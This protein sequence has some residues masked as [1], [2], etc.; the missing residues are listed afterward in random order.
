MN[1]LNCL[2]NIHFSVFSTYV[3][4][5]CSKTVEQVFKTNKQIREYYIIVFWLKTKDT[6]RTAFFF[7]RKPDK[8]WTFQHDS[9]YRINRKCRFGQNVLLRKSSHTLHLR[10]LRAKM[11]TRLFKQDMMPNS[12][13]GVFKTEH[14]VEIVYSKIYIYYKLK[15]YLTISESQLSIAIYKSCMWK[16]GKQS[17]VIFKIYYIHVYLSNIHVNPS[18]SGEFLFW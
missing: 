11:V 18:H 8:L 5:S 2:I 14:R 1:F 17:K 9:V 15:I 10:R 12:I 6:L 3:Q 16:K 4:F 7:R 13:I